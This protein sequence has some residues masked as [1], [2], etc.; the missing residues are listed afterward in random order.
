M[1]SK[2]VWVP[3]AE[4]GEQCGEEDKPA[5]VSNSPGFEGVPTLLDLWQGAH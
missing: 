1:N 2:N 5:A 4:G 3:A